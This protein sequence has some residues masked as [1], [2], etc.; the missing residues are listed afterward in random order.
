MYMFITYCYLPAVARVWI[1]TEITELGF[2]ISS[3]YILRY[4]PHVI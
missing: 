1:G 2:K 4:F 3:C